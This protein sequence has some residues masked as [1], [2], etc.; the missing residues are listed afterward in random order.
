M[1]SKTRNSLAKYLR[2]QGFKV[3]TATNFLS[4]NNYS[5]SFSDDL[6]YAIVYNPYS[7]IASLQIPY[8]TPESMLKKIRFY[9]SQ[10]PPKKK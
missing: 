6:D 7:R 8:A 4:F 1:Q 3:H 2:K 10:A 5:I 9:F